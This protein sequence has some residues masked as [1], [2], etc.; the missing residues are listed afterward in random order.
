[1]GKPPNLV[2]PLPTPALSRSPVAEEITYNSL[3][4]RTRA[5]DR[6][7]ILL[8]MRNDLINPSIAARHFL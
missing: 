4:N 8:A 6:N 7:D 2:A 5:C 1:M 3:K